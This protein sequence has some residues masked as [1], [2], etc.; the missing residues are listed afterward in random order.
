MGHLPQGMS[1]LLDVKYK[2]LPYNEIEILW[3]LCLDIDYL[4]WAIWPFL[5]KES[6]NLVYP[7]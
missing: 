2:V 3:Q 5:D 4:V 7:L 1:A 6:E